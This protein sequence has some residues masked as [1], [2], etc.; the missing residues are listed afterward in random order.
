MVSALI[1]SKRV[2]DGIRAVA[3]VE[4]A[5]L[6]VAGDGPLRSEVEELGATLLGPRF[7]RLRVAR[8]D[9]PSL[10]RSADVF[11]HMSVDEPSA[12]AYCEALAT[13]LP[14]VTHDRRVT[15][16]TLGEHAELVNAE[17][18]EAVASGLRRAF[19]DPGR[20]A[21]RIEYAKA[22]FD[23]RTI[24]GRYEEFFREA[25]ARRAAGESP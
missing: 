8:R 14:I 19:D 3:S 4:G 16:W 2:L 25:L 15:R 7:R 12:N 20:A 6:I 21:Q 10:Y 23:W 22:R 5:S 13:G 17:D 1:P 11:L 24:A 9:M 18:L